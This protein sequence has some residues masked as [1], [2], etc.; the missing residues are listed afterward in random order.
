LR[1]L[2]RR[3]KAST[4]QSQGVADDSW[5]NSSF[6]IGRLSEREDE[7]SDDEDVDASPDKTPPAGLANSRPPPD[8]RKLGRSPPPAIVPPDEDMWRLFECKI[9]AE[10]ATQLSELLA[11]TP[12]QDL[13]ASAITELYK[14]CME[15]QEAI[16][17]QIPWASAG[18]EHSREMQHR[19]ST[20]GDE[21]LAA[22]AFTWEEGL[23]L[24]MLATNEALIGAIRLYDELSLAAQD[25]EKKRQDPPG[26]GLPQTHARPRNQPPISKRRPL[27]STA[28]PPGRPPQESLPVIPTVQAQ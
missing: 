19:E 22:P 5:S 28:H 12:S 2:W 11:M 20:M 18:A 6:S 23:L 17:S 13:Q 7:S 27:V 3:V 21:T 26:G 8:G 14:K 4:P 1:G 10:D 15:S 16:F 24:E 25:R 9:A